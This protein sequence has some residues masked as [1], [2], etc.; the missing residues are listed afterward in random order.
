MK[1]LKDIASSTP[2]PERALSNLNSFVA[3]HSDINESLNDNEL[4]QIAKLFSYSQFLANYCINN[5]DILLNVLKKLDMPVTRDWLRSELS[6]NRRQR[7]ENRST[8]KDN[9][10]I[11]G[12]LRLVKKKYLLHITFRDILGK[13]DMIESM[14]ELSSLADILIEEAY[15]S[16]KDNLTEKFGNP[17]KYAFSVIALGKLGADE[18]NYSSDVDLICVYGTEKGETSG[19]VNPHGVRTNRISNHE[20]YCK[21]VESI[22]KILSTNTPYGF[23][24]R[25]DLRLRPEGQK[26]EL[27]CSIGGYELYYESWGREW[28]RLSLIRARHVAGVEALGNEFLDMIRPFVYRKYIDM[29]SIEEIKR[30]KKKIDA[31][32][33]ED[34][35]KRGYGGIREI[36]FFTQALQLVYGGK[37]RMLKERS[38]LISL[39]RLVQKTLIGHEDYSALSEN[40]L[41]FR[42]LE[43]ILQMFNDIRTHTIPKD[44]HKLNILARKMGHDNSVEFIETLKSKRYTVHNIYDS[45]FNPTI[46]DS[47]AKKSIIFDIAHSEEKLQEYIKDRYQKSNDSR[48][49]S[50]KRPASGKLK[51]VDKLQKMAYYIMKIR[52][53]MSNFQT[54][55]SMR[56]KESILPDFIE[57]A[58]KSRNPEMALKNLQRFAEILTTNESYLHIFKRQE[59]LIEALIEVFSQSEYISSI[60]M[61]NPRY[62]DML[63]EGTPL[64]KTLSYMCTELKDNL[65]GKQTIG[66]ILCIFRKMEEVMLGLMFLN[67]NIS[68]L[69]FMKGL[70]KTADSIITCALENIYQSNDILIVGYGKLGG[71][72][73]T[74]RSDLDIVFVS[75]DFPEDREVKA[76]ER[77]VRA[78]MSYTKEGMVYKIDTRLRP[79]GSKGPLINSIEAMRQYYLKSA[80]EWEVQALLKARPVTGNSTL[81]KSFILLANE[82]VS[83]RGKEILSS[84]I[85]QMRDRIKSEHIKDST[86]LDIKLI[87][88]GLEDIEFLVQ[89]FQ[90]KNVGKIPQ[91]TVQNTVIALKRLI[92]HDV[93][94][95][96]IGRQLL[97]NYIFYRTIETFVRLSKEEVLK[98]DSDLIESISEFLDFKDTDDFKIYLGNRIL[99]TKGIFDSLMS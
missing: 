53:T 54:L 93:I 83:M 51:A 30:L 71:R 48:R 99:E 90:L 56:L 74:I 52:E 9:V 86:A 29:G 60:L 31:T 20:F 94:N 50:Q 15:N 79:E 49:G 25:V 42:K 95:E 88:G 13:T 62:I 36:E 39:H 23:V 21:F 33:R 12:F 18:L 34:D 41:Y 64:R 55:R 68:I 98:E 6:K 43:H 82:V 11:F 27:A 17:Y 67:K 59:A 44:P 8:E 7:T 38:L 57:T 70:S 28:E 84:D 89:Y 22:N 1:D 24:Y 73:I 2:D 78:L 80:H 77:V 76:S 85:I 65:R 46:S 58:L 72:E 47:A 92:K 81:R 32:F 87:S 75:K 96:K 10:D 19:T 91:L 4:H 35:I 37:E 16:A 3:K 63:S 97:E 14:S 26:G 45:L 5:P 69:H 40:Y 66:E 61:G